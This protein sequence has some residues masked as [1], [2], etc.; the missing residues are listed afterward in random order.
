MTAVTAAVAAEAVTTAVDGRRI[1]PT[2][3]AAAAGLGA[4]PTPSLAV[5]AS[6][7][8]PR[9]RQYFARN[10]TD[11]TGRGGGGGRRAG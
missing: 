11:D 5:S 4:A 9:G 1:C 7:G 6:P 3:T 2:W 10:Q 8:E